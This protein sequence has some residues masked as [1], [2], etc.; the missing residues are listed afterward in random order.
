M[1]Y[2]QQEWANDPEGGTPLNATRLNHIE[3]GV[4]EAHEI[5][6]NAR[7][8]S[9]AALGAA[10]APGTLEDL[11]EH[12][13]FASRYAPLNL[14][15][16]DPTRWYPIDTMRA[17]KDDLSQHT[18]T[19]TINRV[20]YKAW[21][22]DR[23]GTVGGF[24]VRVANAPGGGSGALLRLGIYDN[25]AGVPGDLVVDAGT[26][27][28]ESTNG[29]RSWTGLDLDTPR[30][31]VYWIAVVGQGAVGADELGAVVGA[32]SHVGHVLGSTTAACYRDTNT[33]SGALP[34]QADPNLTA[35]ETKAPLIQIQWAA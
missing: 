19:P 3:E 31:D 18:M 2:D 24:S 1:A 34:A 13:E 25:N 4:D 26:V 5:A 17:V 16:P 23:Q 32:D 27:S 8:V 22:P 14:W 7:A 15:T 6:E 35:V 12:D 10:G 30:D 11:A 9:Q 21:R 20:Y 28:A 33:Q 29:I